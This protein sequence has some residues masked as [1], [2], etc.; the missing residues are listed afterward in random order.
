M[1]EPENPQVDPCGP[2]QTVQIDKC[3]ENPDAPGCDGGG[4]TQ[5]GET[6]EV[7]LPPFL[8]PWRTIDSALSTADREI[9]IFNRNIFADV[10]RLFSADSIPDLEARKMWYS[11]DLESIAYKANLL[12]SPRRDPNAPFDESQRDRYVDYFRTTFRLLWTW[13]NGQYERFAPENIPDGDYNTSVPNGTLTPAFFG[14]LAPSIGA[15]IEEYDI[16]TKKFT[17]YMSLRFKTLEDLSVIYDNLSLPTESDPVRRT[18][19]PTRGNSP[20][21][22]P[23]TSDGRF[24]FIDSVFSAE[25]PFY[26]KELNK[27]D[28]PQFT[29]VSLDINVGFYEKEENTPE[30]ELISI[31]RRYFHSLDENSDLDQCNHDDKVQKFTSDSISQMKTA[32]EIFK[33]SFNQY[34]QISINTQQ[35]GK[36]ATLLDEY[37][38]D[39]HIM[40]AICSVSKTSN[41][42]YSQILDERRFDSP[43]NPSS[44]FSDP[45]LNDRFLKSFELATTEDPLYGTSSAFA[46]TISDLKNKNLSYYKNINHQSYPLKYEYWDKSELL[47]FTDTIRSQIFL[48]KIEKQILNQNNLRSFKE[49]IQGKKALSEIIGYRIA[50]HQIVIEDNS[51][52]FDPEPVQEFYLMDSDKVLTI[53]F[54]DTQVNPG[55]KY[56]YR[57]YSLNFVLGS[58]YSYNPQGRD[59]DSTTTTIP[60]TVET[61][62]AI[63]IIQAPFAQLVAH[64][65]E[66][67][68][69]APQVSFLP[70]QGVD[71]QIQI[72]L[73]TNFEEK[74]ELPVRILPSDELVFNK[75]R[76]A[77]GVATGPLKYKSDSIP[78]QYQI[79]RMDSPPESYLDFKN[80]DYIKNVDTQ[81]RTLLF[82]DENFKP[83]KDY[84]YCFRTI[85][86]IG[87]SNPSAVYKVRIVS[88]A[89][90]I[91]MDLKEY[92]MVPLRQAQKSMTFQRVLKIEPSFIQRSLKFNESLDMESRDFALK[93]PDIDNIDI[94]NAPSADSIWNKR[95]K[96]R[97]TSKNSGKKIDLNIRFKKS[98]KQLLPTELEDLENRELVSCETGEIIPP[99]PPRDTSRDRFRDDV[100]EFFEYNDEALQVYGLELRVLPGES[101]TDA[102]ARFRGTLHLFDI[103]NI[104][105]RGEDGTEQW[106]ENGRPYRYELNYRPGGG[107]D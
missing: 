69:I 43:D 88:Y 29:S 94:G 35:A 62:P 57:V 37:Q 54:V 63:Q 66:Q 65:M 74:E 25:Q 53:D 6:N 105:T 38:M 32:N 16:S 18:V 13:Y 87:I 39:K 50:K 96:I 93:V 31:Y 104:V 85:D 81:Q 51:E 72:L 77:Q 92:E 83:N 9:N 22:G 76:Q 14:Y 44:F 68:P 91:Y 67:P 30:T 55:K 73:Q 45:L 86:K 10:T 99:P 61:E 75:M 106:A 20:F 95:Y 34:V 46:S 36:I 17:T 23:M 59:P 41:K 28:I 12:S 89:N 70:F 47:R 3:E 2:L 60:F 102:V 5:E 15:S 100:V 78:V 27:M 52:V 101:G 7:V 98:K 80:S 26:E 21:F 33:E 48:N 84:Y 24:K 1:S 64:I 71:N 40:E 82:L 42:S 107:Y 90:G 103:R 11:T 19:D 4:P 56:V 8:V 58:R 97:V 49:I 79:L